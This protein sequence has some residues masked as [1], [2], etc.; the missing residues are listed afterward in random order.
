MRITFEHSIKD[1]DKYPIFALLNKLTNIQYGRIKSITV[2]KDIYERIE[3]EM[4]ELATFRS[5][6]LDGLYYK[7]VRINLA[8]INRGEK[9]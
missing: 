1:C 9:K 8:Q 4:C 7:G 6:T 2:S 5:S 3:A